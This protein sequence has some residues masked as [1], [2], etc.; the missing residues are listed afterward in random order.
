MDKPLGI[1]NYGHIPHLPD[2]RI[3]PGD[4]KCSEGQALI[5]CEKSR[6]KY[7]EIIVTEK[8]DGSNVGIAKVHGDIIPL[9]RAGYRAETS[10]YK[11]HHIFADFIYRNRDRF[12]SV[13]HD[14][15]RIVG[16][17]CIQAHGTKYSFIVEP[18]FIF[19]IMTGSKRMLYDDMINRLEGKFQVPHLIHRGSPVNIKTVMDKLGI[20]GFSGALEQVEGAVWRVER[21]AVINNK[22]ERRKAVD[23]LVKYVMPDKV[24]G[25]YLVDG[26]EVF[27]ECVN[28]GVK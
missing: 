7:D 25:K 28:M 9:T 5:A 8:I 1:K 10:P 6:D 3:G 13:L 4:H 2:S 18:F 21:N 12:Y 23:F 24:D 17:W 15:E 20:F 16:E 14:G 26:H 19:D 22:G 27:N 11:Q